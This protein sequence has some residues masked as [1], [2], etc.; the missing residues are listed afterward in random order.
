MP[1]DCVWRSARPDFENREA[2]DCFF[3]EEP[4]AFASALS[5]RYMGS[6]VIAML[7]PGSP[8]FRKPIV[9]MIQSRR[10]EWVF[11]FIIDSHPSAEPDAH[12]DV[13]VDLVSLVDGQKPNITVQPSI[14][15]EGAYHGYL[16][17]GVL[18]DDYGD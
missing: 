2:G 15:A 18:T 8:P 7:T 10:P 11:P 14:K 6:V 5:L 13:T 1:T 4:A 3:I 16:T 17:A 9:V 12:W